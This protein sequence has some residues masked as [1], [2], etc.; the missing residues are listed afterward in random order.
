MVVPPSAFPPNAMHTPVSRST[1]ASTTAQILS[2]FLC[3]DIVSSHVLA[4]VADQYGACDA[5]HVGELVDKIGAVVPEA[6]IKV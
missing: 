6:D 2:K 5:L 3:V 4:V 1:E